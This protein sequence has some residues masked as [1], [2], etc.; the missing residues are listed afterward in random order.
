M[1]ACNFVSDENLGETIAIRGSRVA[2]GP[3]DSIYASI[4]I[5]NSRIASI[6]GASSN[7]RTGRSFT[8]IDLTGFLVLP[9]LINAHDHLEFALFPRLGD[10]PYRNYIDWGENIHN[11]FPDLI[12]KHRSVPKNVRLWW[13]G[14][15]NLLCGVTTVS[16]HN[17][18]WPELQTSAFPIRVV[19]NYGWGHSL[20]LGGDLVLARAAT[21]EG[22]PFILHA[23][24]GVDAVARDELRQLDNLGLLKANTVLVHGLAIDNDGAA[25]VIAR[26]T[27]L[28]VCP[29]SNY[30]LFNSLPDMSSLNRIQ[31]VAL[32]TDSPLT[33]VGDLLDEISF[34]IRTCNISPRTAYE[35]VSTNPAAI[36]Q[37]DKSEGTIAES[38]VADLIAVRDTS[39]DAADGVQNLSIED[40][41]FVMVAGRIHLASPSLLKRLPDSIKKGLEPLSI[42]GVTR[43]L[44]APVTRLLQAAEAVLGEDEVRLGSRIV[45]RPPFAK[46]EHVS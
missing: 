15:R 7:L 33:A 46:V 39:A 23:C 43:W 21:P 40:I 38:G 24:E 5:E 32:G 31:H 37:L 19:R 45:S 42:G 26:Q 1:R 18:L 36:L 27:S 35:M 41:E 10:P 2:V 13:G 11:N 4:Q 17:P 25:T 22:R 14:I 16:H 30:F 29:S 20:A 3:Q 28:I 9:G 12:A 44:R 8:T 6:L 34:A